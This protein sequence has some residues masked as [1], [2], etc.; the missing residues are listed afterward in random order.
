MKSKRLF[1]VGV[2]LS[3][4]GLG[5]LV[6]FWMP[7]DDD[8]FALRKNFEI[9]GAIYEELVTSYVDDLDPEQMMRTGLEAM[10]HDLDPYTV[11]IDEADNTDIDIITRGRYGGVGLNVQIRNGR[12]TV[13][14]P[15]ED[16]SA[17][18]QGVHAGDIITHV[19]GKPTDGLSLSDVRNLMNGEP[20]SVVEFIIE[21]EGEPESLRFLLTREEVTLKNVSYHGFVNRDT[22]MGI[23]YIKLERFARGAYPEV[24][25]ALQDMQK[26]GPL[27]G[28]ILDLRDN[29]GGL[30]DAAVEITQLFV[31]QGSLIVSTRGRL[32]ETERAYRSKMPPLLPDV[33]VAVLVNEFSASASEIVAG[34]I[35]DLDRGLVVGVPSFGKG[36]VQVVK[37]LPYNTSLKI[38]T[39][40]YYTP[41][42]RSIQAIDYSTHDGDFERI[43]DSLRHTFKTINGRT[44][45]DGRGIEPDIEVSLGEE[46]ELEQALRRRAAFFFFANHYAAQHKLAYQTDESEAPLVVES[47]LEMDTVFEAFQ[48]W[49]TT[50]DFSYRTSAERSLERL[51]TTLGDMGYDEAGDEVAALKAAMHQEKMA[52]FER[53]KERLKMLLRTEILSRYASKTVQIES[54]MTSDPSL[55]QALTLLQDKTAYQQAM[56]F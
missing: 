37:P 33:P 15:I 11:F 5:V 10:L 25:S 52:D 21:R 53:H 14:S 7:R 40:K 31:P 30:L 51:G 34:A 24:R 12:I 2:L 45:Q 23:G 16:A 20:G 56:G 22:A 39:S 46:S 36:L 9:F 3:T 13:S 1:L 32:P 38:T 19:A 47:L 54:E 44:V 43:P 18:K 26:A 48:E 42:G 41:S 17:Y 35:Q 55:Q 6:G 49:L 50:Q 8:F 27:Q 28:V 29:P 4:L